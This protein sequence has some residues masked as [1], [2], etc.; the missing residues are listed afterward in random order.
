MANMSKT[1][2][3]QP[4]GGPNKKTYDRSVKTVVGSPRLGMVGQN[5]PIRKPNDFMKRMGRR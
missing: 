5:P 3:K 4:G 2:I 1:G